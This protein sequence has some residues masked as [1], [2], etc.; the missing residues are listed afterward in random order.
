[1][2]FRQHGKKLYVVVAIDEATNLLYAEGAS[3]HTSRS[4]KNILEVAHSYLPWQNLFAPKIY[5]STII[6]QLITV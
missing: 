6:N 1:M 5:F 2:E 3:Y 4:A